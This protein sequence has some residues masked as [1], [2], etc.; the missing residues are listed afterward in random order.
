M[1]L[2]YIFHGNDK[3]KHVKSNWVPPVQPSVA[4]ESYLENI[5]V[6]L[7]EITVQKPKYNFSRKEYMAVKELKQN[8]AI[9]LKK[10]DKGSTTVILNITDTLQE[11]LIQ[12]NHRDH[13]LPLEKPMVAETL[14]KAKELI[15]QLH[16]DKYIDD[17]TKEWLSQTLNPPRIPIFYTLTKIHKPKPVGRPIISGCDGPTESIFVDH[18]L[19]PIAMRQK[20]YIKDTTDF[21]NFFEETIIP[22]DTI[23]VSMDF[24]SL[25]TNIP[26][27]EGIQIVCSAYE[28]FHNNNPP[29]PSHYLK[30]MLGLILKENSF[31]FKG[32]NYLQTHGTAMGTKMAVA[33]VSIFMAEIETNL[34]NQ[35]RI[36]PIAWKRYIDDVFSLCDTK[37]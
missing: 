7:A 19:Q 2:Q 37:R 11:G 33:F 12:L 25:H 18:L 21:L 36:K 31:E 22:Q 32:E 13:Y 9:N 15:S 14:Q 28:N 23:L 3:G 24:T 20:S 35:I 29:I 5:K 10:A 8:T 30:E 27:E 4:L 16:N 26:Q 1:R 17:M 6:R 34:L